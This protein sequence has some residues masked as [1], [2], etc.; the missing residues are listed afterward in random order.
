MGGALGRGARLLQG[1]PL[2]G[3]RQKGQ[4]GGQKQLGELRFGGNDPLAGAPPSLPNPGRQGRKGRAHPRPRGVPRR[5]R[6]GPGGA[7][8]PSRYVDHVIRRQSK[9]PCLYLL[10]SRLLVESDPL[11]MNRVLFMLDHTLKAVLFPTIVS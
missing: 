5:R 6:E 3:L 7:V 8:C 10:S 11:V 2:V 4:R 9:L 1:A